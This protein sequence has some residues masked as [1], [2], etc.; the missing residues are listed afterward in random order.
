MRVV[1]E[2]P[3]RDRNT[4][5]LVVQWTMEPFVW[6][7]ENDCLKILGM[8]LFEARENLWR[9]ETSTVRVETE[10]ALSAFSDDSNLTMYKH[11]GPLPRRRRNKAELCKKNIDV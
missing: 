9:P 1:G 3:H 10:R 7:S 11:T 8:F 5:V 2:G 6:L 4:T